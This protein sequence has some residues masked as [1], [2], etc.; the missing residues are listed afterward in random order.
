MG[1]CQVWLPSGIHSFFQLWRSEREGRKGSWSQVIREGKGR[2]AMQAYRCCRTVPQEL[3]SAGH[4]KMSG[5]EGQV[6]PQ[7]A[8]V[9]YR[10][11]R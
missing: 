3:G 10:F 6:F 9:N 8:Y 4:S 11:W 5:A 2:K 1:A 7:G